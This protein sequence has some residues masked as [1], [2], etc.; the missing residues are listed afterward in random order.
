MRDRNTTIDEKIGAA[1]FVIMVIFCA[2]MDSENLII[3]VVGMA[4]GLIL[5]GVGAWLSFRRS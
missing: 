3:P 4:A 2:S 1:G 5:M